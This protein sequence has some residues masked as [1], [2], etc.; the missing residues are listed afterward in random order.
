MVGSWDFNGGSKDFFENVIDILDFPLEDVEGDAGINDWNDFQLLDLPYDIPIGISSGVSGGVQDD[1]KQ[2][3]NLS[4]SFERTLPEEL[5]S[6]AKTG[7]ITKSILYSDD[8]LDVKPKHLFKT[9]SPVSILESSS[10]CFVENPR[11]INLKLIVPV[12][13]ARSKRSRS[14]PS[15]FDRYKF[16]FVASTYSR[17]QSSHPLAASN[18]D[19]DALQSEKMLDQYMDKKLK[20][21]KNPVNFSVM[22]M[23][24]LSLQEQGKMKKCTHCEVTHTPQWREGPKGPKT[25]CNACGVR[26][27]VGRLYPEYRPANS[28]TYIPSVHS[29]SHKK[30]IEMRNKAGATRAAGTW[31]PHQTRI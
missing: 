15:N 3:Q 27:R 21:K 17:S 7:S 25:L 19:S 26:W 1:S 13:H 30:V 5:P 23:S 2:N 18:P 24:D 8:S 4:T 29:N 31:L 14:R 12:K 22:E 6:A 28:P 10:S 16:L 11:T 9:S 20:R